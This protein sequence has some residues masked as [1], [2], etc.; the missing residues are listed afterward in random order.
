MRILGLDLG[1]N[2][3]KAVEL[4]SAF[5]RYEIHEYHEQMVAP[6][7]D[8]FQAAADLI[9]TLPKLDKKDEIFVNFDGITY[10]YVVTDMFEVKPQAIQVLDQNTTDSYLSLVTCVPPGHPLK[11]RRLIVRSKLVPYNSKEAS[12]VK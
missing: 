6:G 10:K 5:G 7:A 1:S 9:S 2:S 3:V 4:D 11:P 8:P 12:I